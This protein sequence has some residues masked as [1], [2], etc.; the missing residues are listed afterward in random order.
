MAQDRQADLALGAYTRASERM[1]TTFQLRENLANNLA[2]VARSWTTLERI[3]GNVV[4][5][6]DVAKAQ[7]ILTRIADLETELAEA[8]KVMNANAPKC[9]KQVMRLSD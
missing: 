7:N 9:G 1:E 2:D 5:R 4:T 3:T 6:F 8:L